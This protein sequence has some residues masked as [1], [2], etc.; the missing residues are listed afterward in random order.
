MTRPLEWLRPE[1]LPPA[2]TARAL[3]GFPALQR[4]CRPPTPSGK[5]SEEAEARGGAGV[6]PSRAP[7][8]GEGVGGR[9][10]LFHD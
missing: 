2:W 5:P 1:S 7:Q 9:P 4:D 10:I 3:G 8:H 6:G